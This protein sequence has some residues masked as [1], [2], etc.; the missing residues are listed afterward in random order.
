M[1]GEGRGGEK[2]SRGGGDS[3]KWGCGEVRR[4]KGDEEKRSRG[5]GGEKEERRRGV[6]GEGLG[7]EE[8]G[9]RK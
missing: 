7:G 8:V 2:T 4:R 3:R 6:E 9:T 5:R 1:E